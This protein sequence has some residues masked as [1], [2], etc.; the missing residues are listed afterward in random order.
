M[1]RLVPAAMISFVLLLT[2]PK[3]ESQTPDQKL[4]Q[5][6]DQVKAIQNSAEVKAATAHIDQNRE[7]ILREWIAITEINA[8][9]R[10]E[11]ERA[12]YY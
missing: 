12:R 7:Q 9:S 4:N 8:P 11:R 10:Q 5:Y 2:C 1:R 6:L 3:L